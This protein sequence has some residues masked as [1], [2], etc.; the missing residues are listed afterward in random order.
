MSAAT[1][2]YKN[3]K[4]YTAIATATKGVT[5]AHCDVCFKKGLPEAVY[6]SHFTKSAPGP[7]GVVCCPTILAAVCRYC[8]KNGHWANEKFCST[9]RADAKNGRRFE[10]VEKK[11]F[12]VEKKK[13]PA[14][15][16]SRQQQNA[17]AVLN[18]DSDDDDEVVAPMPAVM[19]VV[20]A[21]LPKAGISWADMAKK[22]AVLVPREEEVVYYTQREDSR[23]P[24]MTASEKEAYKILLERR[25]SGYFD[26]ERI[27]WSQMMDE[28]ED[29]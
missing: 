1:A 10:T 29:W 11:R 2:T 17:F 27:S 6:K 25:E 8:G 21:P 12:D 16:V 22:P 15:D 19:P 5:N 4:S 20:A 28:D 14:A 3:S 13:K 26:R 18:D 9:M 24:I 7:A 23:E